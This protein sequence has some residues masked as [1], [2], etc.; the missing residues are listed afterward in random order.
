MR[1]LKVVSE[2]FI[3]WVVSQCG[4]EPLSGR[5]PFRGEPTDRNAV[6][7]DHDGLAALDLVKDVRKVPCRLS[8]RYRNHEYILSDL[9]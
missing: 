8:G 2:L 3:G 7:G 9:I 5:S 1:C 6:A 4:L